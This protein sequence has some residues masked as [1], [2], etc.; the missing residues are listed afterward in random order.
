MLMSPG[1]SIRISFVAGASPAANAATCIDDDAATLWG[2][3]FTIP[4]SLHD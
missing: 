3:R 2:L 4:P 1:P